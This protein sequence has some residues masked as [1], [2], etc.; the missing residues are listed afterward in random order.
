[1]RPLGMR[2][3]INRANQQAIK[4]VLHFCSDR[5]F[6]KTVILFARS[7]AFKTHENSAKASV[8]SSGAYSF[9]LD[10]A[11]PGSLG[12]RRAAPS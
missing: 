1:M 10:Y 12:R 11:A 3:V 5:R 9:P 2:A 6:L 8:L 4:Q 7:G